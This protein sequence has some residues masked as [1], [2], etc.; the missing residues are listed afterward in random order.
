MDRAALGGAWTVQ[1]RH[2]S[3]WRDALIISA[4]QISGARC[5]LRDDLQENQD[6]SGVRVVS[7]VRWKPERSGCGDGAGDSRLCSR[8]G[9]RRRKSC[10]LPALMRVADRILRLGINE[11][12]YRRI[13][14]PAWLRPVR[15]RASPATVRPMTEALA[16][17]ADRQGSPQ[18]GTPSA[19]RPGRVLAGRAHL[20]S[21]LHR[22]VRRLGRRPGAP[23]FRLRIRRRSARAASNPNARGR[24]LP[25]FGKRLEKGEASIQ[26]ARVQKRTCG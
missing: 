24:E 26:R 23:L 1:E 13:A 2:G 5:L 16:T 6:F 10:G 20:S 22:T 12:S 8:P 21:G 3:R 18:V 7:P 15:R 11:Q 4:A 17:F 25:P 19:R 14:G 9:R